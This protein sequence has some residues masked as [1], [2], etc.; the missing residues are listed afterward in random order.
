MGG[1]FCSRYIRMRSR[2]VRASRR[3]QRVILVI[4][5]MSQMGKK[6]SILGLTFGKKPCKIGTMKM[7]N[8]TLTTWLIRA[9]MLYSVTADI[10][11]IGGIVWL[12][13]N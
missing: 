3:W 11:V 5:P 8:K 10:I 9:Y 2:S 13:L 7:K 1:I 6:M 4:I 12:I